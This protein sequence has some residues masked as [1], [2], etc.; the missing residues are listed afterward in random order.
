L[1]DQLLLL[2]EGAYTTGGILGYRDAVRSV[3]K[4]AGE[5][6][7][8]HESRGVEA[9]VHVQNVTRNEARAGRR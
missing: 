6:V 4:A 1:A 2:I 5:L 7:R 3:T 8:Q 9:A